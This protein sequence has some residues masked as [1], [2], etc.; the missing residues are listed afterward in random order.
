MISLKI[1]A[2]INSGNC[3]GP[4]QQNITF[5]SAVQCCQLAEISATGQKKRSLE[6][7]HSTTNQQPKF[8]ADLPFSFL[9]HFIRP[10][11]FEYCS[12][13]HKSPDN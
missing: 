7:L 1:E 5:S 10:K 13:V 9:L 2:V 3:A 8:L 4:Y 11:F 6:N 12:L